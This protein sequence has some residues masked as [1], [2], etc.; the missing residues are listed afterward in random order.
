[1]AGESGFRVQLTLVLPSR[2]LI[3]GVEMTFDVLTVIVFLN[4]MIAT[5]ALWR[6]VALRPSRPKEKFI[7]M[8]LHS[9]PIAPK[10]QPHDIASKNL[11]QLVSIE[12]R[13]F[14]DDFADFAAV[15]NWWFAKHRKYRDKSPWCL[16][17]LP[18]IELKL[19]VSVAPVFGRRY[20]IF[21]NQ[22]R[23]GTLEVSS[24]FDYSTK[25]P[26]VSSDIELDYVRLLA[27]DAI[28]AFLTEIAS[29][30]S[31]DENAKEYLQAR[32]AIDFALMQVLWQSQKLSKSGMDDVDWGEVKLHLTG[33][34]S[35]YL[36]RR[37]DLRE[38]QAAPLA[39]TRIPDFKSV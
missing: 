38:R 29:H 9:K 22:V 5:I 1:M 7:R 39:P 37:E 19:N 26:N 10:P 16:Q 3:A 28:Y 23:L 24:S 20:A 12:D 35:W 27:F 21:H 31:D 6:T 8:L 11:S 15:I 33:T 2:P 14:F 36:K 34:A 17:E 4:V 13:L 30:V 18:D 25:N 32:R